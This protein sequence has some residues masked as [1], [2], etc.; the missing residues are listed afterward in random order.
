MSCAASMKAAFRL[1]TVVLMLLTLLPSAQASPSSEALARFQ[2][3]G[4]LFGAND[5][6]GAS[7]A[8]EAAYELDAQRDYLYAWA[9]A[10]RLRGNCASAIVLYDRYVQ[11]KPA[12]RQ[13]QAA[14][15]NRGVCLEELSR[16]A[17]QR[18]PAHVETKPPSVTPVS[19]PSLSTTT[20][21]PASSTT[22]APDD[23][24]APTRVSS[25][26]R[27]RAHA[28]RTAAISLWTVGLAA[29]VSAAA[30]DGVAAAANREIDQPSP[31]WVFEPSVQTRRDRCEVAAIP[32]FA[33]GGA[34]L[35]AGTIVGVLGFR[36]HARSGD[37]AR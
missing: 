11:T 18:E 22:P 2:Q 28:Y 24:V 14:E 9:Q 12:P 10:E 13:I 29:V 31:G 37:A 16:L 15:S 4:V 26:P 34:A 6:A 35:L 19:P 1:A 7:A 23:V 27:S 32:L 33:V 17:K 3:G 20:T 21:A 30:L 36:S 8:F 5:Y 25:A